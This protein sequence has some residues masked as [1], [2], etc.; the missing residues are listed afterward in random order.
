MAKQAGVHMAGPRAAGESLDVA[1]ALPRE[2]L[3]DGQASPPR[4]DPADGRGYLVPAAAGS[5]RPVGDRRDAASGS[6]AHSAAGRPPTGDRDNSVE[7]R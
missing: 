7:I 5:G 2:F 6:H 3:A 4:P 1:G